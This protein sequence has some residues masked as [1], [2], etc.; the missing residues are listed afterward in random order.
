M[1]I[2]GNIATGPNAIKSEE[3]EHEDSRDQNGAGDQKTKRVGSL[4]KVLRER[5]V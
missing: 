3:N 4:K 2:P 1:P 5:I